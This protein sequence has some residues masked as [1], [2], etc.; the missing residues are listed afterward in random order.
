MTVTLKSN[1]FCWSSCATI[2]VTIISV[3]YKICILAFMNLK[4]KLFLI[5][6]KDLM[7]ILNINELTFSQC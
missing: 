7:A 2:S 1:Y 4:Y 6:L 5:F 3:T